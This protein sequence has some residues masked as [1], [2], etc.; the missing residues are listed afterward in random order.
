MV[1]KVVALAGQGVILVG[2]S[3]VMLIKSPRSATTKNHKSSF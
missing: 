1:A 3:A 2:G